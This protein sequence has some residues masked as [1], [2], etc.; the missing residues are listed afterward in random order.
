MSD[1]VFYLKDY[2]KGE[3]VQTHSS[4]VILTKDFAYKIKKPVNFGFLDYST[5]EKRKYYIKKELEINKRLCPDVYLEMLTISKIDNTYEFSDKN[6]VEYILK[7]K[8]VDDNLFLINRLDKITIKD[9]K[10]IARVVA[11]F[12]LNA[13]KIY[14]MSLYDMMKFN[15]DENFSQTKEFIDKTISKEDYEFIK[16]RV[17]NFY[18]SHKTLFDK[19]QEVGYVVDGHGDIRLEHVVM[20]DKIC[21]MDVIEFNDRFRIQDQIN[22]MCFLSME[23]DL[24]GYYEFSKVYEESYKDITKDEDFDTLINFYKCYRAYVRGKVSSFLLNDPHIEDKDSIIK[25]A[26]K[27]FRLAKEYAEKF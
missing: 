20:S 7:M 19:R 4:F 11:E 22:D 18:K 17:D 5:L 21:I 23:L 9:I 3:L 1:I 24:R 8:R 25:G 10:N 6:P 12:H 15:T 26:S 14:D 16:D 13:K 27:L 2:L